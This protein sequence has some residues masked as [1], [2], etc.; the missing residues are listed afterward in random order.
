MTKPVESPDQSEGSTETPESEAAHDQSAGASEHGRRRL[1]QLL[2]VGG[3]A[4][5]AA[6][7]PKIWSK[8]VVDSVL[9]PTHAQSSVPAP[10]SGPMVGSIGGGGGI[11]ARDTGDIGSL[12]AA[13]KP[14]LD[15][16]IPEAEAQSNGSST[17]AFGQCITVT[18]SE[19]DGPVT[20]EITNV[21]SNT[22]TLMGRAFNVTISHFTG[23]YIVQGECNGRFT[24]AT[25]TIDD[26]TDS[27]CQDSFTARAGG[28]CTPNAQN[29]YQYMYCSFPDE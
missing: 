11:T 5:T 2:T 25:G 18:A 15:F 10:P 16:L 3:V 24:R 19:E 26:L 6:A 29:V 7:L 1:V 20:V 4:G 27:P 12:A 23:N 28:S 22:G 9:L 17:D 8:P 13:G 14:V 21:G